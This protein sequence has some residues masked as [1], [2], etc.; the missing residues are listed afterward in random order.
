MNSITVK[1]RTIPVEDV[2]PP[3]FRYLFPF[4][5]F[6]EVQSA[7][8]D[9]FYSDNN[10]VISSPTGSGKTVLFELAICRLLSHA[11]PADA[12]SIRYQTGNIFVRLPFKI[13]YLSPTKSLCA[14]K[15]STWK[16]KFS[17]IGLTVAQVDGDS[18]IDCQSLSNTHI[19]CATPE[20]WDAITRKSFEKSSKQSSHQP[21]EVL[22]TVALLL[23][24]EVHSLGEHRGGALEAVVTRMKLARDNAVVSKCSD[25][26]KNLRILAV[27]AT[28]PNLEDIGRWLNAPEI[29]GVRIFDKSYRP[30]PLQAIV[31]GFREQN[32]WVF[33]KHLTQ[34]LPQV[35]ENYSN[36]KPVLIFCPSRRSTVATAI[37]LAERQQEQPIDQSLIKNCQDCRLKKCIEK[38]IAF[39]NADLVFADRT[40]I[41][42]LYIKGRIKIICTTTTLAQGVNLPAHLVVIK[43][44]RT[45]NSLGF[46]DY[47][48][49]TLFQM[50][51]RAGRPQ[52]DNEGTAVIMTRT[53]E[54]SKYQ[55]ICSGEN[56]IVES[57]L[58]TKLIEHLNAEICRRTICNVADAMLWLKST[59]LWIRMKRNPLHYRLH[60]SSSTKKLE[61]ELK[62]LCMME[63]K[64]LQ[65]NSM[66]AWDEEGFELFPREAGIIMAKYYISFDT[67]KGFI[68]QKNLDCK[69]ILYLLARSEEFKSFSLRKCEKKTLSNIN[70]KIRY[71]LEADCDKIFQP[72]SISDKVYLLLQVALEGDNDLFENNFGLKSEA[73]RIV[74]IS[75]RIIRAL[76][77]FLY[78]D[79]CSVSAATLKA[80][81]TIHRAIESHVWP[82]NQLGMFQQIPGIGQTLS[83]CLSE[84]GIRSL[85]Q[86]ENTDPRDIERIV[87]RNP[88]FGNEIIQRVQSIPQIYAD[89]SPFSFSKETFELTIQY[90]LRYHSTVSKKNK[91][92]KNRNNSS[93]SL[94]VL[95]TD[96][97]N[98]ILVA[99]KITMKANEART[100]FIRTIICSHKDEH[101]IQLEVLPEYWIGRDI[102]I[103]LHLDRKS[104][105]GL[106]RRI[107]S[108]KQQRTD[109]KT[110]VEEM[111]SEDKSNKSKKRKKPTMQRTRSSLVQEIKPSKTRHET[112]AEEKSSDDPFD[113]Y[114]QIVSSL[115]L[116]K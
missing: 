86:L 21:H 10:M 103:S 29:N 34:K 17:P 50:I 105:E 109:T 23:V 79:W 37:Y 59:F 85:D 66:I 102:K 16:E 46:H 107:I 14:E 97:S 64:E 52:Y 78:S 80:I 22:F 4:E 94:T 45:Y 75:S 69:D 41:E 116:S 92:K 15:S 1:R 90:T 9:I 111:K 88:P 58:S 65:D 54:V 31:L 44:T 39:H 101:A 53:Q 106:D 98:Q 8:L 76:E 30:V 36:Q 83:K 112:M 68:S 81:T 7:C 113:T 77:E 74:Q 70:L 61:E 33:D 87:G 108:A 114:C 28:I 95:M 82:D 67:M 51:G 2:I 42:E 11:V 13:V 40:L 38:G 3:L 60:F 18:N 48:I 73:N 84:N 26:I 55:K 71:P 20:K 24:D 25:P 27:S 12:D 19:I 63:L 35:L 96:S 99:R 72:K 56:S 32:P 89:L 110:V 49:N 62:K 91:D 47:D 93:A 6:N 104:L 5:C 100:E 115:F 57:T 43:D